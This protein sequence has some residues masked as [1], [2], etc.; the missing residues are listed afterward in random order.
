[1]SLGK[2]LLLVDGVVEDEEGV[3]GGEGWFEGGVEACGV[4]FEF[5]FVL[6]GVL[7]FGGAGGVL[8]LPFGGGDEVDCEAEGLAGAEDEAEVAAKV[9]H[10]RAGLCFA[11]VAADLL[12]V[13]DD[14]LVFFFYIGVNVFE[15]VAEV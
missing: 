1:M 13:G 9:E 15:G 7:C 12:Y 8:F 3:C 10:G 4:V 5:A 11:D 6:G 2:S 14:G